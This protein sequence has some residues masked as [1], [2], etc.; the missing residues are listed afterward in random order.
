M[1]TGRSI[2]VV[3]AYAPFAV[4]DSIVAFISVWQ[5]ATE[6]WLEEHSGK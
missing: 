4:V 3:G 6:V 5:L 1:H 2:G